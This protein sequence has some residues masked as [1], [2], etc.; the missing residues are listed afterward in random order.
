MAFLMG[1]KAKAVELAWH[2]SMLEKK[3]KKAKAWQADSFVTRLGKALIMAKPLRQR[4]GK[5]IANHQARQ[6]IAKGMPRPRVA[7]A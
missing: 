2:D 7:K 3:T 5:P 1:S 4:H 6:C